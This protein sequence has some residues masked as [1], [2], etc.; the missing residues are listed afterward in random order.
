MQLRVFYGGTFDPVHDGHL[1]VARHA[2]DVLDATVRLMPAADPPH[3]DTPGASAIHRARM[4]GL[5]VAGERGLAVDRRELQRDGRSYSIDTVREI[6]DEFGPDA[7]VALL[8][9]AD[10]L[11]DLPNWKDWQALFD[12]THFVVAERPG[13]TIDDPLPEPLQG[14]LGARWADSAASLHAL[15]AGGVLRLRQPLQ[16]ES[17]TDVRRRIADG[18]PWSE[19][20]PPAVAA[21]IERHNLYGAGASSP[22]SL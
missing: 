3:R 8:I 11:L 16:P 15:P 22:A 5:A 13:S 17:A 14:F 21:Y 12:V 19:L 9:G 18:R 10:S 20:V 2:R 6:R 7:P 1:A 4:L